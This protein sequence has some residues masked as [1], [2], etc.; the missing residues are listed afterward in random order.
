VGN[1]KGEGAFGGYDDWLFIFACMH[2]G[3]WDEKAWLSMRDMCGHDMPDS[4]PILF[5][6]FEACNSSHYFAFSLFQDSQFIF[7]AQPFWYCSCSS[8]DSSSP[9]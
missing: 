3:V 6:L 1:G 5:Y 7:L 4:R 9:T 8:F 2:G